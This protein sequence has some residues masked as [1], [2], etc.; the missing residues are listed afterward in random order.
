MNSPEHSLRPDEARLFT[1]Q[2]PR[3]AL[4]E[5]QTPSTGRSGA[6][7][8]SFSVARLYSTFQLKQAEIFPEA[9]G[10]GAFEILVD[11]FQYEW[12]NRR[13]DTPM[14]GGMRFTDGAGLPTGIAGLAAAHLITVT[15]G[16]GADTAPIIRLSPLG[17]ARLTLFFDSIADY[18]SMI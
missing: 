12:L 8:N 2:G 7:L 9:L 11:L 5:R 15:Q 4:A 13:I 14:E 16:E 10:E 1:V 3:R 18:I 6:T 17:R